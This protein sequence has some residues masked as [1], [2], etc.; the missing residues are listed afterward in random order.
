MRTVTPNEMKQIEYRGAEMGIPSLRMME[1]AGSAAAA[2]LRKNLDIAKRNCMIFCGKGGNGGD[3]FVTARKLYQWGANVL[4]VLTDGTPANQDSLQMLE[5]LSSLNIP[6]LEYCQNREK[7]ASYL[8]TADLVIDAVYGIS[9]HGQLDALHREICNLI[10]GSTAA[11]VA[12]D[13]PSGVNALTASCDPDC[14]C[15]DFTIV[16]D[17]WKPVHLFSAELPCIGT[18]QLVDIGI[19]DAAHEGFENDFIYC[20]EETLLYYLPPKASNSHK[21]SNGRLL[22]ISGSMGMAGAAVF[23]TSAALCSGAG[24][25]T[26]AIPENLYPHITPHLVSP[27]CLL[28][29]E[30]Q[31]QSAIESVLP[32]ND[33]VA[34]GCGLG[35]SPSVQH[36]VQHLTESCPLPL[37]ID[38]D[39]INALV[40]DIDIL[41]RAASVRILTP[42]LGEFSRLTKKSVEEIKQNRIVLAKEFS[43]EYQ[44]ILVLKGANTIVTSPDGMVYVNQSGCPGLAKA[45]SGDLLTGII[46]SLTAQGI[47]PFAAAVCGVYLH[48]LAAQRC[49]ERL[50][51]YGMQPLDILTD[52]C[53]FLA[54]NGR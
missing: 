23:S 54:E 10:N 16:F 46:A 50:S 36:L 39:G 19:P 13:V 26:L 25:V 43:R 18:L 11:V 32:K 52:L 40:Q 29:Q 17:S 14:V 42:H 38:A 6:I 37:I 21:G 24:Y 22:N 2:F 34:I 48:G 44:V 35:A 28:L 53:K 12:L 5:R 51:C 4:V 31:Q 20:D 27:V 47:S 3:G 8:E 15:A 30:G 49:A 7:I 41:K 33:A 9:F 1:N 45:G